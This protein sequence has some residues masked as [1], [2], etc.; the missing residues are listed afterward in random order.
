MCLCIEDFHQQRGDFFGCRLSG[1]LVSGFWVVAALAWH[2][3][4]CPDAAISCCLLLRGWFLGF[5]FL[6]L[7]LDLDL[8][9]VIYNI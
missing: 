3:P 5:G 2:A 9:C 8:A 6:M 7:L 4:A 1:C